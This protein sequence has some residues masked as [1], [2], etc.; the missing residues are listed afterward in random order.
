MLNVGD[1]APAFSLPSDSGGKVSLKELLGQ[2]LVLYFYP[3]ADTPGCTSE[4]NQFRDAK[5]ELE[6][7]GAR[8]V[9]IS[10]DSVEDLAK[11]RD[12]YQL[13][14]P[15]LGDTDHKTLEGY[16]VWQE[17]NMYGR[18]V[19]GIVRTTY[20]VGADGTVKNVFPRVKV[21]GHI[22]EVLKALA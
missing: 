20:I 1:K 15:L 19:K 21:D 2:T 13:N 12:K 5:K 3:R 16:G 8:V 10:G 14:F 18:K 22:Q 4:A 11:F 17:K 7:L 9:G 6:R